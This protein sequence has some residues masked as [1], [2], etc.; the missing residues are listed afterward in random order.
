MFR[1]GFRLLFISQIKSPENLNFQCW[2]RIY[3]NNASQN[4]AKLQFSTD[5]NLWRFSEIL[6]YKPLSQ[7]ISFNIGNWS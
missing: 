2:K 3:A 5:F 4:K 6:S 1:N 7:Q